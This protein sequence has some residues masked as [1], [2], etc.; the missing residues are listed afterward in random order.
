MKDVLK[1]NAIWYDEMICLRILSILSTV[2][3]WYFSEIHR[4]FMNHRGLARS[5]YDMGDLQE[6]V[7]MISMHY[8]NIKQ[9]LHERSSCAQIIIFTSYLPQLG[10]SSRIQLILNL[11]SM[12]VHNIIS[13]KGMMMHLNQTI[14]SKHITT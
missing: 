14:S 10:R 12:H 4:E 2:Y 6:S 7:R 1:C 13:I 5:I 8:H 9:I 11:M 3:T